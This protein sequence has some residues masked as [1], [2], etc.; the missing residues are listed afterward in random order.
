MKNTITQFSILFF[1]LVATTG[2]AQK[3]FYVGLKAGGNLS[4]FTTNDFLN[5]DVFGLQVGAIGVINFNRNFAA[6]VEV[7][8]NQK[9]G[10]FEIPFSD[11]NPEVKLNY[12]SIPLMGKTYLSNNVTFELGPEIGFLLSKS[13]NTIGNFEDLDKIKSL[14]L[15][16]SAG[17]SF[18]FYSGLVIQ[19][20]YTYGL[21]KLVDGSDYKN[22]TIN[23]SVGYFF[24]K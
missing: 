21:S 4:G 12:L 22:S 9:G 18:Q 15:G 7:V 11:S 3:D 2:F 16:A 14:D 10:I 8:F 23:L 1:L 6:Q 20:R 5:T 13:T 17:F 24:K 19:T